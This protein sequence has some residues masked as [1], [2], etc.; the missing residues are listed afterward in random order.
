MSSA[1]HRMNHIFRP[2]KKTYIM[3]MDHG[4]NF[5]VLPAMKYPGKMIREMA[6][7]GADVFLSTVGM[8]DI[9]FDD[10]NIDEA[11]KWAK[12]GFTLNSGQVCI[13]G[14]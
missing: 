9:V 12:F 2:D 1:A 6:K 14:G 4:A 10:V 7:A 5:N 8:A 13:S 3:A 11:V